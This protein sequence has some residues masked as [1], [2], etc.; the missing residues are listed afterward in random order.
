MVRFKGVEGVRDPGMCFGRIRCAMR[1]LG[2]MIRR[3]RGALGWI[4]RGGA[5][6]S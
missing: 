2:T 1:S 3:G 5:G 6:G 4:L